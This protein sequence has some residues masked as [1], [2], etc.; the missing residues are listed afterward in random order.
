MEFL[1]GINRIIEL[2]FMF[3]ITA[4]TVSFVHAARI[5][6]LHGHHPNRTQTTVRGCT[7]RAVSFATP[8]PANLV[9]IRIFPCTFN[10]VH[11]TSARIMG[12][13]TLIDFIEYYSVTECDYKR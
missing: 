6:E 11:D 5:R 4:T 1:S 8:M 9:G 3:W 7:G 12:I 10:G 2:V 13:N